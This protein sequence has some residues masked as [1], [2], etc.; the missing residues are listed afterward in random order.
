[1]GP[2]TDLWLRRYHPAP[3]ARVRLACLP[4]AGGSASYFAPV[5]RSL[6]PGIDVLAV[7]YP[8]R[9]DR[10]SEPPVDTVEALADLIAPVL[11][12][13]ADLPLA[14]FGHSMGAS[15][16]YEVAR[17]LEKAGNAP[18]VLV[19]SGRRAPVRHRAETTHLR[20]DAGLVAEV[21]ALGGANSR[22]LDDPELRSMALPAL[23]SDYRAAET[24]RPGPGAVSCPV[25]ALVGESDP[26]C[27]LDEAS[28]WREH[29]AG[30]FA[31][32]TFPGGHFY[33]DQ[34]A[35]AVLDVLGERIRALTAAR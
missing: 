34:Q 21:Q 29:T 22:L 9:Q 13:Y 2:S 33:L 32:H 1:M 35:P 25:T 17:R 20:D 23:R 11:L 6:A 28:S 3:Q 19:V 8:G 10:L 16:G 26:K 5:A 14:L 15:V 31:L 30:D 27:T 24:Y 18:L 4:H 12:P 7:Q